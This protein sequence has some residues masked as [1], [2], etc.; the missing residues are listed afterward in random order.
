[1]FAPSPKHEIVWPEPFHVYNKPY[2]ETLLVSKIQIYLVYVTVSLL[3]KK[4]L[5]K[6]SPRNVFVSKEDEHR[7]LL[8]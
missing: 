6:K 7:L 8:T 2:Y 3:L 4:I 5:L 1:M